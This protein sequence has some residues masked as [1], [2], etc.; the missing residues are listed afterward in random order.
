MKYL[1]FSILFLLFLVGCQPG[2]E[3]TATEAVKILPPQ[4]LYGQLF[5]DVQTRTDL[6]PDSKTFVDC[7]PKFP[8]STILSNYSALEGKED[9]ETMMSFLQQHFEIPGYQEEEAIEQAD[10]PSDHIRNLWSKLERP[11]DPIKTGTLIPLKNAYIVPGGRFR[12]VYY[13]DSYFTMLGLE[14]DGK[15]ELIGNIVDNFSDLIDSIGFIPNGNRTY[16][17]SRSQP[18]FY[19]LMVD[20]HTSGNEAA[21]LEDYLASLMKEHDFW[22][23]EAGNLSEEEKSS[24]RVVR[25]EEGGVLNRYW[26]DSNTPRPESHREDIETVERALEEYEGRSKEEV[27]RHLRAAAE[28]GWDFST[29]W[30]EIEKDGEFS[31]S[32]IHTTDII[33][34]DLNSLL[35]FVETMIAKAQEAKGNS[36]EAARY[37]DLAERRKQLIIKYCWDA[38]GGFFRDYDF[39]KQA[40]TPVKSLAGL[41]PLFFGIATTD[42]ASQ[43]AKEVKNTFLMPGGVVTTTNASGQ[44]WDYPNGWA[45]LQWMT[46]KGLRNYNQAS[47]ADEISRRWLALNTKVFENTNKMTEKYN[48]VDIDLEGGGGEYPNQDGFGWTN[49][50]FQKLSSAN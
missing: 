33:P 25:L 17:N 10:N 2:T 29:R 6:F 28:S 43:V 49:G 12:E 44:Q 20:L 24:R 37:K 36:E 22:M 38:K 45:P 21:N 32:S 14:V 26:D 3:S 46:I 39:V 48:V 5:Y 11:A 13:W 1:K 31:L 27:Y 16:Y 34:V 47:L 35:Y 40:F 19:A 41:Y 30:F 8:A 15:T 7:V 42:Q 4:D 50:V 23:A 18:P 9:T